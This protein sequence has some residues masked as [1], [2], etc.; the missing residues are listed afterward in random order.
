MVYT[1]GGLGIAAVGA[2]FIMLGIGA[3]KAR[4]SYDQQLEDM[5]QLEYCREFKRREDE[6]QSR[7]ER[8][9]AKLRNITITRA[10]LKSCD[11]ARQVEF[12]KNWKAKN[13]K[14]ESHS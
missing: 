6:E 4:S 13:E 12:L 7:K 9:K 11:D 3:G 1:L 14:R 2:G 5:E 8:R 10:W